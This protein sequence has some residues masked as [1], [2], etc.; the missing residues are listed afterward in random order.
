MPCS[1][2]DRLSQQQRNLQ[3]LYSLQ[4]RTKSLGTNDNNLSYLQQLQMQQ[5]QEQQ[6]EQQQQQQQQRLKNLQ[7]TT[8]DD[9]ESDCSLSIKQNMNATYVNVQP[10]RGILNNGSS[11]NNAQNKTFSFSVG[12]NRPTNINDNNNYNPSMSMPTKLNNI[13]LEQDV[14]NPLNVLIPTNAQPTQLLAD[15]F[16][17]WRSVIKSILI[18]LTETVS[19]QDEIIRQQLRLSHAIQFPFFP[20]ENRYQPPTSDEKNKLNQKFFTPMGN[21]SI[22]D[23]P[24]ILNNFHETMA[25]NASRASKDLSIDVI[26]RLEELRSDLLVKIKEIKSLQSDFK[27]SVVK[28]HQNTRQLMK[29]FYKAMKAAEFSPNPKT[30]PFLAKQQLEVQIRKQF[31][32]ENFLHDAFLNLQNSGLELERVVVME[33]QNALTIYARILGEQAQIV[34]DNLISRMDLGFFSVDP[35]FE[36]NNFILRDPNFLNPNVPKRHY[37]DIYYKSRDDPLT[38]QVKAGYMLRRSKYLRSYT[39]SFYVLSAF[40]LH[41]FKT[42]DRKHDATPITSIPLANCTIKKDMKST[43]HKFVIEQKQQGVINRGHSWTFKVDT[44]EN[45]DDWFNCLKTLIGEHK[46][47]KKVQFLRSR[48]K[49]G[50]VTQKV[51]NETIPENDPKALSDNNKAEIRN[52]DATNIDS[53]D[54][55]VNDD[56][57]NGTSHVQEVSSIPLHKR[58]MSENIAQDVID[59]VSTSDPDGVLSEAENTATTLTESSFSIPQTQDSHLE[60]TT[61]PNVMFEMLPTHNKLPIY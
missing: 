17:A 22:Q 50:D 8:E 38:Y 55:T 41:E 42:A 28:E 58:N 40:Y 47:E 46:T 52:L 5:Q 9:N 25:S 11:N 2:S 43:S 34:F 39:S 51:N 19:I 4:V 60:N 18:Y 10:T 27:S 13:T 56:N 24:T 31:S 20:I 36:F 30:D 15:R 1:T 21:G 35:I 6:Q 49:V 33:I 23:L 3:H 37:K 44:K 12:S 48:L 61:H 59:E 32:E 29:D 26:P 7:L 53:N 45:L 57:I 54:G 16:S 14:N